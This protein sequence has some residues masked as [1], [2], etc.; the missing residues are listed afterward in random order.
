MNRRDLKNIFGAPLLGIVLA[1]LILGRPAPA[2]AQVYQ[3]EDEEG[4]VH[5]ADDLQKVPDRYRER[6]R[7]IILPKEKKGSASSP[8][9]PEDAGPFIPSEKVDRQGH[10]RE[11]WQARLKEWQGKKAKAERQLAEANGRL[12]EIRRVN[13][14]VALMQEEAAVREEIRRREEELREAERVLNEQLPEEARKAEAPPGWL[15]E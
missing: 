15:R 9:S 1:V 12:G 13:P 7:E 2:S 4:T 5:L 11:W 3:W 6:A 8:E 14:S 10:N